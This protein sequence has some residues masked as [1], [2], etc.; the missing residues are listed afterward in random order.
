MYSSLS[1][2]YEFTTL[3]I[4]IFLFKDI[5]DSSVEIIACSSLPATLEN[6]NLSWTG[7]TDSSL[8]HL[9]VFSNL[10]TLAIA[11]SGSFREE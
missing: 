2:L 11:G 8:A 6:L 7:L 4:I 10:N 1:V 5:D 9:L 3:K